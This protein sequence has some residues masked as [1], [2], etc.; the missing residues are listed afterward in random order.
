[1]KISDFVTEVANPYFTLHKDVSNVTNEFVRSSIEFAVKNKVFPLFYEGCLKLGIRL[2]KE[3]ELLVGSYEKRRKMQLEAVNLLLDTSDELDTELM[4]FKTFGPFNY[5]PDDIDVLLRDEKDLSLLVDKLKEKG[6]F[7]LKIG[8]P[9][10]VLRKVRKDAYVDLDIHKRLAVGY[11]DVFR[12][13]N[14]W[15][16]HAYEMIKVDNGCTVLKLSED[17]EVVREAAYSLLKD[18]NLSIPGLYLAINAMM[19]R[20]IEVIERIAEEENLLLPLD[21]YLNVAYSIACKLFRSKAKFLLRSKGKVASGMPLK[22]C[23]RRL[24]VPYPYPIS[25]IAWAYISKVG[26]EIHRNR[27]LGVLPQLIKQPSS[28]GISILLDYIRERLH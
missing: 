14:L 21:L 18:F 15:R 19:N 2:P 24:R 16:N 9:E 11:L 5:I 6:Y 26:L 17:Y 4:F 23:K 27:N 20:D 1:V 13:E 12:V 7:V 22:L 28:K 3:A 10:V 8:T 25:V